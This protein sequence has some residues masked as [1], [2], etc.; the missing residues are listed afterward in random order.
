MTSRTA[1]QVYSNYCSLLSLIITVI[2]SPWHLLV[3][4]P[5]FTKVKKYL[6]F[7]YGNS[8]L[9]DS[10]LLV[11]PSRSVTD[12]KAEPWTLFMPFFTGWARCLLCRSQYITIKPSESLSVFQLLQ[13]IGLQRKDDRGWNSNSWNWF[14]K[15]NLLHRWSVSHQQMINKI[16]QGWQIQ[17]HRKIDFLGIMF[18]I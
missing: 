11:S 3:P 17:S 10:W 4:N 8:W 12:G 14:Q 7:R 18:Y 1:D 16:P 15:S 13:Q 6:S 2:F 9:A 5:K